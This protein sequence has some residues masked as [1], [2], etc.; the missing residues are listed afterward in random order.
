MAAVQVTCL[1]LMFAAVSVAQVFKFGGCPDVAVQDGFNLT[2]YTGKWY[3]VRRLPTKF[4]QGSCPFA[5]FT[6][7]RPGVF[8]F[9]INELLAN[10]SVYSTNGT[11]R[12][13]DPTAHAKLELSFDNSS[14]P[15]KFW[16]WV[17]ST[18]Y[19]D[20]AVVYHCEE[21]GHFHLDLAWIL[22]RAPTL[23]R[24]TI[25]KLQRV[26]NAA[27]VDVTQLVDDN[28]NSKY[29]SIMPRWKQ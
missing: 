20:H 21:W 11:A 4:H 26:L 27:G 15:G 2:R 17:L 16:Y 12:V 9:S 29:C 22:G 10:G 1:T 13:T 3:S 28:Q 18:D 14:P 6:L 23:A 5:V 25:Q 7:V 24:D 19:V 8:R